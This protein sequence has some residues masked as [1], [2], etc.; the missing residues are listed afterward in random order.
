[1]IS[2]NLKLVNRDFEL[3]KEEEE[4]IN[5]YYKPNYFQKN[6]NWKR[7]LNFSEIKRD[8]IRD[9][10]DYG[11]CPYNEKTSEEQMK[12]K[13][14]KKISKE[15]NH[16]YINHIKKINLFMNKKLTDN[17][18]KLNENNK[19]KDSS[20]KRIPKIKEYNNK[21]FLAGLY[22]SIKETNSVNSMKNLSSNSN[23][24]NK[25]TITKIVKFSRDDI[26]D[27]NKMKKNKL[28]E[29]ELN[30]SFSFESDYDNKNNKYNNDLLSIYKKNIKKLESK[31][32]ENNKNFSIPNSN[33]RKN[34]LFNVK[35]SSFYNT[36][37]MKNFLKNKNPFIKSNKIKK[38]NAF[39]IKD[40]SIST[41]PIKG[42]N[43]FYFLLKINNNQKIPKNF[44]IK[45][46][47]DSNEDLEN[48]SKGIFKRAIKYDYL[49][50]KYKQF[51]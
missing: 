36:Q 39:L 47:N 9:I 8:F 31:K 18:H 22:K 4:K 3:L 6:K 26:I 5:Y 44:N 42:K 16:D 32:L 17:K 48:S 40:N 45:K 41:I 37:I 13:F 1:M 50:R 34:I 49:A 28:L 7:H 11:F 35:S 2:N 30:K 38:R 43:Y 27:I 23:G 19:I 21:S 29:N 51:K 12:N 10:I 33:K 15:R 25:K 24:F 14:L 46:I 20:I